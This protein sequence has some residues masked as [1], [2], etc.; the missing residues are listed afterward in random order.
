MTASRASPHQQRLRAIKGF[1]L[2]TS[3]LPRLAAFYRDVLGFAVVGDIKPIGREEMGLL[4]LQGGGRRQDL[5]IGSQTVA[6]DEFE[7]EGRAYPPDTDAASL[8]FQHLA[9]VV[10]EIAEAHARLRDLAPIS[11][12]GPQ[13]LPAS[14]GGVQAF[15]FRDP[16]GHPLE[17]L[18]F[19][20]DDTPTTWKDKFL[21]PG[22]ISLGVDH[23]AISVHDADTSVA[24]YEGLAL[25]RGKRTFNAGAAQQRLDDLQN[26][27]V[28]VV[29]MIPDTAEPHLELLAYLVPRRDR[30]LPSR[31]NDV[32]ATRI[33]WRGDKADLLRD[34]DGHLQQ[35][36]P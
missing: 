8:W 18:Q 16:D 6:I 23:S 36:E 2:I 27:E 31:A 29:P 19:P 11:I 7:I 34:P 26:V 24:F 5:S 20:Q 21:A 30:I 28:S 14:S 3:D 4:G 12:A 32:A 33:L 1:R 15:K 25:K 35:I 13:Q 22:Q 17:L 9:L 10:V